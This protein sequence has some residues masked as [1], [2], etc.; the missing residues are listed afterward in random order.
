LLIETTG[1]ESVNINWQSG[2]FDSPSGF[3]S[4]FEAVYPLTG[5]LIVPRDGGDLT[6]AATSLSV[7]GDGVLHGAFITLM[8]MRGDAFIRSIGGVHLEPPNTGG[9]YEQN[10][11]EWSFAERSFPAITVRG[12]QAGSYSLAV[13]ADAP[14]ARSISFNTDAT[15]LSWNFEQEGFRRFEFGTN[16]L[17]AY[18]SRHHLAFTEG[19]GLD[20]RGQTNMPGVLLSGTGESGGGVNN[21]WGAK[22][23]ATQGVT[24]VSAGTYEIFH[25][26]GHSNY[27]ISI[28]PATNRTAVVGIKSNDK[29]RITLFTNASSPALSDSGFDFIISGRNY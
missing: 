1:K 13:L 11:N 26:I 14:Q 27:A 3:N 22:R 29:V 12:V 18:Y 5:S 17:M 15:I 20:V 25:S 7:T 23:H 10:I 6:V 9:G 19:D 2:I 24:R 8:L 16:G 4:F 28:T 21:L